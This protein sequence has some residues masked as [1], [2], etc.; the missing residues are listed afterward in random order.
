MG[1]GKTLQSITL[2]SFIYAEMGAKQ[3]AIVVLPKAVQQNWAEEL[4]RCV[5]P[6][7][8]RRVT[9]IE[10]CADSWAPSLPVMIYAG[11]KDERAELRRK[12]GIKGSRIPLAE[13]DAVAQMGLKAA[14]KEVERWPRSNPNRTK[15]YPIIL[16]TCASFPAW[17]HARMTADVTPADNILM[18]DISWLWQLTYSLIVCDEAHKAKN[19][20]GK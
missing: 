3:P 4:K 2:L 5:P 12:L 8:H 6:H 19:L 1:T 20:S 11:N 17:L 10:V 13:G 7:F 16:V 18:R 9:L 14:E 15:P